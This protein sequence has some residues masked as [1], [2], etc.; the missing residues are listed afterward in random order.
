[1]GLQVLA[2]LGSRGT[3][4]PVAIATI[5]PSTTE[6]E[7]VYCEE[8]QRFQVGSLSKA[9]VATALARLVEDGGLDLDSPVRTWLPDFEL[10]DPETAESV[11]VRQLLLHRGGWEGDHYQDF[12]DGPGALASYVASLR[13]LP[14]RAP[15]DFAFS[16]SNSGFGLLGHLVAERSGLPFEQA[17]DALVLRP[18]QMGAS[19]YPTAADRPSGLYRSAHPG[20]GFRT[21]LEDLLRFAEYHLEQAPGW[22]RD[23]GGDAGQLAGAMAPGWMVDDFGG[24]D[25]LRWGGAVSGEAGLVALVPEHSLAFVG[26]GTDLALLGEAMGTCLREGFGLVQE[27]LPVVRTSAEGLGPYLGEFESRMD[28]YRL[29]EDQ[30]RLRCVRT[31]RGGYPDPDSPGGAPSAPSELVFVGPDAVRGRAG[32][33]QGARGDF[34]R[35]PGGRVAWFRWEG[36]LN[37][38]L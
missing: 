26:V 20:G 19:G 22:L 2:R 14:Q 16:Y 3:Q 18:L 8:S 15:L 30:G 5:S 13:T 9:V 11:T 7:T 27:E 34:L 31:P 23:P 33:M 17:V 29:E 4:G 38:R 24:T 10:A 21:S 28:R 35:E 37:G 32:P 25:V 1:M 6:I 36:R 12:G